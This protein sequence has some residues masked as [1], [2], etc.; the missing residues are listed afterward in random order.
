MKETTKTALAV[1]SILAMA[2]AFWLVLIAP[3][4]E[5][6]NEL[7]EQTTTL[8]AEVAEEGRAAAQAV[9]SKEAFPGLYR[10][11]VL[12]G[13]SVP[14]EAGTP[15]LLVQLNGIGR[16]SETSFLS[17]LMGGGAAEGAAVTGESGAELPLGAAV[18]VAGLP[19][20]SYSL[21]FKGGFFQIADFIERLDSLV[22]TKN[23]EVDVHGRLVTV[24]SFTLAPDQEGSGEEGASAKGTLTATFQVTTYVAPSG[25]G[26][27]AGA[28]A[29]GPAPVTAEEPVPSE[30]APTTE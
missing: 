24:D 10:Q 14:A 19:T 4:R 21:T 12:L 7:S 9:A 30:E 18:G 28:T 20:M 25:Q 15:S 6:A 26:V 11:M 13:K 1:A 23:G 27:T 16:R 3:K 17:I 22:E 5:Q 29:T 8:S 2:A